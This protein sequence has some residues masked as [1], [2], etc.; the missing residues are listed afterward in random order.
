MPEHTLVPAKKIIDAISDLGRTMGYKVR[1]EWPIERTPKASAAV[2]IAWF[3][4]ED[5]KFPLMIFEVETGATAGMVNNAVKVFS[6]PNEELEK[7]LFYFHVVL[8]AGVDNERIESI[9]RM[10][11]THNYR[12]YVLDKDEITRLAVDVLTQ[13]RRIRATLDLRSVLARLTSELWSGIDLGAVLVAAEQLQFEVSYLQVYGERATSSLLLKQRYISFLRSIIL[14]AS[15]KPHD[16]E[17]E[18]PFFGNFY[19]HP[20]H[21]G[22]L[23]AASPEDGPQCFKLLRYWQLES[24]YM[25]QIGPHWG[26][27]RDYDE[28]VIGASPPLWALLAALFN[29]V[30]NAVEFIVDEMLKVFSGLKPN[31]HGT[32]FSALWL[33]HVSGAGRLASAFDDMAHFI[34]QRKVPQGLLLSPPPWI[35]LKDSDWSG[36]AQGS[37][38]PVS[39]MKTFSA[40]MCSEASGEKTLEPQDI[41]I[42]LLVG[43]EPNGWERILLRHLWAY[44]SRRPGNGNSCLDDE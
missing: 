30:P 4:E 34:N 44:G 43:H 38:V 14:R 20:I 1:C 16:I 11:G 19:V 22:I 32:L 42:E 29:N 23:A 6:R 31:F 40:T 41:A 8:S 12:V 17:Y 36:A 2:D 10:F 9:R 5:H 25:S 13:H 7:P 21:L 28:F 35:Q 33:L 37:F 3:A 24:S 15:V 39:D 27:N 26:L 18:R